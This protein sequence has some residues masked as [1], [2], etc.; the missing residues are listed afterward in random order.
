M[1]CFQRLNRHSGLPC[2]QI[3]SEG[4]VWIAPCCV[5]AEV[6]AAAGAVAHC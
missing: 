3:S 2:P 1:R 6:A 4:V 5:T